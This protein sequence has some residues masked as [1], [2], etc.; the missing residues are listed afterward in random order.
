[1][2]SFV[3][4]LKGVE[5]ELGVLWYF[6]SVLDQVVE[7]RFE[8]L[9]FEKVLDEGA[10]GIVLADL[11]AALYKINCFFVEISGAIGIQQL[12][13]YFFACFCF[14]EVFQESVV[15]GPVALK[16]MFSF[17]EEIH[18]KVKQVDFSN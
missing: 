2:R 18:V 5:N 11:Y 4:L 17:V 7:L 14:E 3:V 12:Q 16:V 6:A 1:M 15:W 13:E 10:E 9:A 8:V